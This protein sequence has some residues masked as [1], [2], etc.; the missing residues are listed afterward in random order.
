MRKL[1]SLVLGLAV[2]ATLVGCGDKGGGSGGG[3]SF[4]PKSPVGTWKA[5]MAPLMGIMKPM[6][7]MAEQMFAAAGTPEAKAEAQKGLEEAKAKM[8][9]LQKAKMVLVINKDGTCTMDVDMPGDKDSGAGTW[10]LEGDQLTIVQTMK[11]GK[12]VD[13][14]DEAKAL[15]FKDGKLTMADGPIALTFT[16]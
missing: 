14:K 10:K 15:T 12:P 5:D 2:S 7:D 3:G 4:D 13:K 6:M 8:A 1:I 9:D 16:R 11:N